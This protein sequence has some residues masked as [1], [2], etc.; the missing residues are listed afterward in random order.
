MLA[1]YVAVGLVAW[2]AAA[3]ALA[4]AWHLLRRCGWGGPR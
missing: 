2:F 4:A 1:L 3:C